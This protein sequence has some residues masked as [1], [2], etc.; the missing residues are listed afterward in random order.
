MSDAKKPSAYRAFI[1]YS[2]K[3]KTFAKRL[4]KA[5]E[6]FKLPNG[7]KF[8]RVFRDDDELGGAASLSDALEGA[9]NSSEDLIV[10]ASP[11]AVQS[12][13]VNQE[14]IQYKKLAD[15][16][17]Q[18]FAVIID[19]TPHA[20]VPE[21]ECLVPALKYSVT[22]E[23][24]VTQ[25]P[26]EPLAP[27]ARKDS[28]PKLVTRI[29]AGIENVPFDTLWQR[30]KRQRR[31]RI[32]A[33]C[34]VIAAISLPI[35]GWG[36]FTNM[37]LGKT[38]SQLARLDPETQQSN[39]LDGYYAKLLADQKEY[40]TPDEFLLKREDYDNAISILASP[41][42]NDDGFLDF[43]IKLEHIEYCGSA[44]CRHDLVLAK[45]DGYEKIYSSVGGDLQI[46]NTR[47]NKMRDF[48][49]GFGSLHDGTSVYDMFRFR[50]DGY[51]HKATAV[52][53]GAITYCGLNSIFT[54]EPEGEVL[55]MVFYTDSPH[56]N[57]FVG[58]EEIDSG[59]QVYTSIDGAKNSSDSDITTDTY[60]SV[61][62]TDAT[63]QFSLVH[64]WKGTY[65]V[66]RNSKIEAPNIQ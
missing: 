61:I 47:Q 31:N 35:L 1:S 30:Q 10:I 20:A 44:G 66:R 52:C 33:S 57:V 25:I 24:E 48:A 58:R 50:D 55:D 38:N 63:G 29:V 8:G 19:G 15:P 34:A 49:V 3:D 2:Q 45:P 7:N 65:G 56:F 4:H 54:K 22:P 64:I 28:F 59:G 17:K 9:I 21:E 26:D 42:L 23:G 41:D 43:F 32:L 13:W 27:D 39:F 40:N 60:D 37:E 53:S 14:V 11:N 5:L 18:V 62:G 46:L 51:R 16:K 6:N 36:I 12:K